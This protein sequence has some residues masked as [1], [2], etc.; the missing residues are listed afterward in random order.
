MKKVGK[1]YASQLKLREEYKLIAP[2]ARKKHRTCGVKEK[3]DTIRKGLLNAALDHWLAKQGE[4]LCSI[5]RFHP[6]N[7]R[8][9]VSF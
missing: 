3:K 5:T 1:Y 2:H 6:W 9:T 4:G 8:H 7:H